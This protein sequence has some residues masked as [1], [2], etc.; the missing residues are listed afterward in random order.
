MSASHPSRPPADVTICIPAWQSEQF[1]ERT[2]A[3]AQGQ[4]HAGIRILVSVD[5]S[6]D[7]TAELCL[8]RARDDDRIGVFVQDER[9]GW[10]KNVNFLLDRAD[11]NFFFLY[12][13]DDLIEASYTEALLKKLQARP[14]VASVHCDMG[15][16]GASVRISEGYNYEGSTAECLATFLVAPNRGSPLRSLIRRSAVD[17]R[18]RL[19]TDAPAGFWANE[20]FLMRLI[21]AGPALR[22]PEVLYHR[23]DKRAGGLTDGWKKLT[24]DQV[25]AGFREN[26]RTALGIIA[27][28]VRSDRERRAVNF[29]LY[30]SIMPRLRAAEARF[31]AAPVD[32]EFLSAVFKD[33]G[34]PD[35]LADF[36]LDI[37]QWAMNRYQ[38]L[39]RLE[40]RSGAL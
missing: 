23:W 12:F 35:S 29:C 38:E 13:H 19:P 25:R 2:L 39:R 8:A 4:T 22:V 32:A 31:E 10:A 18:L 3:C 24:L 28:A 6:D 1:I 26:A 30:V 11:T 36:R 40:G 16:F 21:A 15:H 27:Q 34:V 17:T 37:Q 20:P 7:A 9:L 14:D 33:I 5:R